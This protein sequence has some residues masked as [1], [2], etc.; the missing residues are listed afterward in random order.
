MAGQII[1]RGPNKWL[2]KIFEGRD[3]N[4]GKR[5][6]SAKIILGTKKDA[7]QALTKLLLELDTGTFIKPS[8]VTVKAYCQQWLDTSAKVRLRANTHME[9]AYTLDHYVVP[10]IGNIKL[11]KLKP[12][13]IQGALAKLQAKNLS[14]RTIRAAHRVLSTALTEAVN[15]GLLVNNPAAAVTK[16]RPKPK[17]LRALSLEQVVRFLEA[18]A[19]DRW[20][21]VFS[22]ALATG[23]R[24]SEMLGLQWKDIDFSTGMLVVQR[25]LTRTTGGRHL[26]PPKNASSRR[27][28]PLPATTITQLREHQAH[29]AVERQTAG[30][31]YIDAD[32]VFA[33]P[34]GRH[35][36]DKT[37]NDCHLKHILAAAGLPKATRFYDLRHT[38]ATL[39]LR[40]NVHPKIVS[41]RLGHSSITVTMDT[42]SHVLPTMQKHATDQLEGLLFS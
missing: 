10:F 6:Y 4:T 18:A 26:T 25:G 29:Q 32:F 21:I 16:P 40:A 3:P 19:L 35:L 14:A 34:T 23:M 11:D 36:C 41:E 37:L 24:P 27:T 2:I 9:Y 22:F 13:D 42:Y 28:I 15:M 20:G 8:S 1:P 5:N 38:C 17:E 12:H 7:Q 31:K 30:D 33:M 39:L